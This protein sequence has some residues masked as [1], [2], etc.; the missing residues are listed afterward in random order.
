MLTD[1]EIKIEAL[2]VLAKNLGEVDAER[3]VAL[4]QPEPFDYTRWQ[5]GLWAD[6][7][8]EDLSATAMAAR[9]AKQS[10]C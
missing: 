7:T 10:N 4:I 5:R 9:R 3:F 1:T 8:I 6:R 2:R